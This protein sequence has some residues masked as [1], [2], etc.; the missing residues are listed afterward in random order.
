MVTATSH[1]RPE[2]AS[3]WARSVLSGV[4]PAGL[5]LDDAGVEFDPSSRLL[6]AAA[7]VLEKLADTLLD[8]RYNLLLAD[9]DGHIVYR[10]FADRRLENVL[11]DLGI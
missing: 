8:T 10:W 5:R 1:E 4:A 11:D 7:P 9:R 3:S 2:I 6:R